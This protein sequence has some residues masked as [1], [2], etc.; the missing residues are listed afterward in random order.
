MDLVWGPHLTAC[1]HLQSAA[2]IL[3]QPQRSV[4]PD[5]FSMPH[6]L[7]C[8]GCALQTPP[9]A[10]LVSPSPAVFELHYKRMNLK[11]KFHCQVLD[12]ISRSGAAALEDMNFKSVKFILKATGIKGLISAGIWVHEGTG[13][14]PFWLQN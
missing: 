5:T 12:G 7:L 1:R 4:V 13:K 6:P 9:S 3:G 2:L 8:P 14:H 11:N 10:A